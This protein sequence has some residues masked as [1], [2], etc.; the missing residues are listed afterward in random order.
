[1]RKIPIVL[2]FDNNLSLPAAVCISSLL[3]SA[4]PDTFYDVYILHSGNAPEIVGINKICEYYPNV[5]FHFRSV[6]N[7]FEN[8]FEIR[9]ITKTA[10]YRLLAAD[11][12][13][14]YDR[15]I[16]ADVDTVFRIDLSEL[17]SYDLKDNYVG[18]VYAYGLNTKQEGQAYIKSIGLVPG[19]YFVS[20]FLLMDLAKIR[21]DRLV[22]RFIELAKKR[23]KYQDQDILNIV[24]K[25]KISS[26]PFIYHMGVAA[27]EA[28]SL[29][30]K[31]NNTELLFNPYPKDP[32]IY[33]NIHYNGVKPWRDWCPNLDQWW[34]AYRNSPIYDPAFYFTFFKSKLDYLDQLSLKK[35]IKLLLRYFIYGKKRF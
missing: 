15:V 17:Y 11:Y 34:E 8:A 29:N 12:I 4:L 30:P 3:E 18:A 23:F 6:G 14:E 13:I 35:R 20:G 24:C 31:L 33:S 2:T 10:Y 26:L 21:Q 28:I 22:G 32:L 19:N 7:A 9:G 1:M 27:C 25:D 5:E 16:Y